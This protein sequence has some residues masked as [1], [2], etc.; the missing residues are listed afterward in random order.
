M[1]G[2]LYK[3]ANFGAKTSPVLPSR[4]DQTDRERA[5]R[6]VDYEGFETLI[7]GG[8]VTKFAP[9]EAFTQS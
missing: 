6:S 2:S 9:H 5:I 4:G 3:S 7:I 8:S 1:L